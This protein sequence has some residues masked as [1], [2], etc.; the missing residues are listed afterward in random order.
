MSVALTLLGLIWQTIV[1]SAGK[2][3]G[4]AVQRQV[5]WYVLCFKVQKLFTTWLEILDSASLSFCPFSFRGAF[6]KD[7]IMTWEWTLK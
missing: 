4:N 5:I 1:K 7:K 6:N 2:H 3:S